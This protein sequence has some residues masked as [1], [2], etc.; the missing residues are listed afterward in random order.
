VI[1][2]GNGYQSVRLC[3]VCTYAVWVYAVCIRYSA[4][5]VEFLRLERPQHPQ[6]HVAYHTYTVY[7]CL[8]GSTCP[9]GS[10]STAAGRTRSPQPS[11]DSRK[12]PLLYGSQSHSRISSLCVCARLLV[13]YRPSVRTT[14]LQGAPARWVQAV[15]LRGGRGAPSRLEIQ[16]NGVNPEPIN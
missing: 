1:T 9:L 15:L 5:N 12:P 6:H 14:A 16:G 7:Y 11:R 3:A 13:M 4:Y 10:S 2:V 8:A